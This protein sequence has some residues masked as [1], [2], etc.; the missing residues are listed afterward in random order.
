MENV[1]FAFSL[2]LC[3]WTRPDLRTATITRRGFLV[4][5]LAFG[6]GGDAG[7]AASSTILIWVMYD[8]IT[9]REILLARARCVV[10]SRASESYMIPS[11]PFC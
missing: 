6:G 4:A 7:K 1:P 10:V 3:I 9:A 8:S 5:G 2:A 11:R